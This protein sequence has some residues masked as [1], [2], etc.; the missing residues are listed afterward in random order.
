MIRLRLNNYLTDGIVTGD[1]FKG[2]SKMFDTAFK[3]MKSL[4]ILNDS[5]V[6]R[7]FNSGKTL[8][9]IF[10]IKNDRVGFKGKIF[11]KVAQVIEKL[12]MKYQPIFAVKDHSSARFF[13]TPRI[14]VPGDDFISYTNPEIDDLAII[15]RDDFS[16]DRAV[17]GYVTSNDIPGV[18]Q[19]HEIILS[20]SE[21]YLINPMNMIGKSKFSK[22][23]TIK[24]IKTY[25]DVIQ[26]YEDYVSYTKWFMK[27]R[28]KENPNLL[29][30]YRKSYPEEWFDA[31]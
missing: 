28:M 23:K 4:G 2:E 30:N 18:N 27:M 12:N 26:M 31:I 13:G 21:Y 8:G 11:D 14:I 24:D 25:G 15:N 17:K 19:F 6:W 7:G 1:N 16:V 29:D 3:K 22:I 20:C 5:V 10:L 9:S